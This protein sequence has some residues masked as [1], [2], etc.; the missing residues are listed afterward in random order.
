MTIIGPAPITSSKARG[1]GWYVRCDCGREVV[2]TGSNFRK[3]LT[4]AACG[5]IRTGLAKIIHNATKG[6]GRQRTKLYKIWQGMKARC[7]PG[8][9]HNRWYASKGIRVCDEWDKSFTA[10]TDWAYAN[11]YANGLTIDREDVDRG[12]NSG[13]CRWVTRTFNTKRLVDDNAAAI[14][15]A[16]REWSAARQVVLGASQVTA[17]MYDRLACAEAILQ[18]ATLKEDS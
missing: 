17:E 11:G 7:R 18:A 1:A 3:S 14:I 2:M 8:H 15:L 12:Y 16:A 5:N 9:E 4:C 10:F 13:N 6:S